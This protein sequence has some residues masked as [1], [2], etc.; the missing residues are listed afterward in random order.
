MGTEST[1]G[2]ELSDF[3]RKIPIHAIGYTFLILYCTIVQ[4]IN[5]I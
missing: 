1:I 4:L 3:R 5:K 2:G